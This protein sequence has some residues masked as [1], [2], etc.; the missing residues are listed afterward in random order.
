MT[1]K[2]D[3]GRD[4]DKLYGKPD[5]PVLLNQ[6]L[7]EKNNISQQAQDKMQCVYKELDHVLSSPEDYPDPV[8]LIEEIEFELQELWGFTPSNKYHRYWHKIK[9][10]YCDGM[11]SDEMLGTGLRWRNTNC[12]WHGGQFS[13]GVADGYS[14]EFANGGEV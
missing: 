12:P 11:D 13:K 8:G 10:C 3:K 1:D 4:Y 14:N 7:I 2:Y 9:G 5:T 6:H